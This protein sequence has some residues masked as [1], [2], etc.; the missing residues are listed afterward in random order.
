MT[1]KPANH[2][3]VGGHL[4]TPSGCTRQWPDFAEKKRR[5]KLK[6]I[7]LEITPDQRTVLDKLALEYGGSV[8]AQ[9][10]P[11]P[12]TGWELRC[13]VVTKKNAEKLVEFMAEIHISELGGGEWE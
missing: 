4:F 13:I 6:K 12:D 5:V 2:I 1:R 3:E 9:P 8:F 10:Y 7:T 11:D